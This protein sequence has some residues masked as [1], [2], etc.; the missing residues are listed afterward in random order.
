MTI[1]EAVA[2]VG[3]AVLLAAMT[4][5]PAGSAQTPS[6]PVP[7]RLVL[8]LEAPVKL[9][10][11]GTRAPMPDPGDFRGVPAALSDR[12]CHPILAGVASLT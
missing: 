7:P 12:G 5:S 1:L 8:A 10:D 2:R 11:V 6:A 3:V 4:G 9:R